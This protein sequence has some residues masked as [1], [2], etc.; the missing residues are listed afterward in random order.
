MKTQFYQ[1]IGFLTV[2]MSSLPMH[3]VLCAVVLLLASPVQADAPF[4]SLFAENQLTGW[5]AV[6]SKSFSVQDGILHCDGSGD[7]PTWLV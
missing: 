3:A 6:G 7:Y 1:V 2:V 4:K 5:E